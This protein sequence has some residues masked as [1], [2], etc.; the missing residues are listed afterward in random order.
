MYTK[1]VYPK[2]VARLGNPRPIQ[3][4]R[5][6]MLSKADGTVL[7]LGFG[8]GANLDY[9]DPEK[10]TRLYALEPNKGMTE[11]AEQHPK[12]TAFDILFLDLPGE[13][14]PLA[15]GSVDTV[16]STFTLCTI[17]GFEEA[18]CGIARILKPKGRLIFIENTLSA[19]QSVQRWQKLWAAPLYHV[20]SGL[21]LTRDIP[22]VLQAGN[23]G[24]DELQV[25]YLAAFPKSWTHCCWGIATRC[26]HLDT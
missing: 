26:Q 20:F 15:D 24:F 12:K 13:Q 1:R 4:L 22:A 17:A 7:E 8:S 3:E 18:I 11:I 16:V 2:L 9:Y 25:G 19:D 10:V 23:F 14:L 21:D 5:R 6:R